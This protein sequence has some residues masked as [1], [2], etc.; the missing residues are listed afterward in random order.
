MKAIIFDASTLISF[1]MT[2]LLNEFRKLKEV[3]NGKFIITQSVKHEIIDNPIK[4]RRFEL[5]ALKLKQLVDEKVLELPDSLGVLDKDIQKK[6]DEIL[7]VSNHLFQADGRDIAL[8][9]QGES[10]CLALSKILTEKKIEHVIAI[11][12]RTAR[13]LVEKPNNLKLLLQRKLHTKVFSK[14]ENYSSFSGFKIIRSAELIYIA[15][16]KGLVKFKSE[17]VLGAMIY[18]L[19]SKGCSISTQEIE[20]I[21]KIK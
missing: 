1:A 2:G 17:K 4:I 8:L 3:F 6:V 19:R 20:E 12:E 10:S 18:A 13:V 21:K 14:K 9:H 15:Y 5:E 11:D 16:K 7:N